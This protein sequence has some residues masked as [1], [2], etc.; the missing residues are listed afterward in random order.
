MKILHLV[1]GLDVGGVE[2]W[3]TDLTE[4]QNKNE[5]H[6][7][8]QNN[9][10]GFFEESILSHGGKIHSIP[11]S[12]KVSGLWS[13][14]RLL[15]TENF[16]IVHSHV[17]RSSGILL[18]IAYL[19][20]V[21]KRIS[22]SHLDDRSICKGYY[23]IYSIIMQWFI[24]KFSNVMIACS[25]SAS[26]CLFGTVKNVIIM[27]CGVKLNRHFKV[28]TSPHSQNFKF[29]HVGR[30]SFEKNHEFLIKIF[31]EYYKNNQNSELYLLG[32]GE[33][34][35]HIEKLVEDLGISNN[36]HFEGNVNDVS[37]IMAFCHIFLFPSHFEGL[38][39][40]LIE[41]QLYGLYCLC[42]DTVPSSA[43]YGNCK[44]ISI[45]SKNAVELWLKEISNYSQPIVESNLV[46]VK[47]EILSSLVNI[48][49]NLSF[50]E[51]V[52]EE[53]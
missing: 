15:K 27:P 5:I 45:S 52:Y 43:V 21:K 14:Y 35:S 39:L 26:E 36:V 20:G 53:Y 7:L 22:H 25:E 16:D 44:S 23:F 8:K 24:L 17:H 48:E 11:F 19:V 4:I 1:S 32:D 33:D 31:Y 51:K 13:F 9:T 37:E 46:K 50:V 6:F 47:S 29:C 30:F 28:D 10:E 12:N 38:G 42:S 41:A 49:T 34:R 40:A 18:L 2:R 3:L